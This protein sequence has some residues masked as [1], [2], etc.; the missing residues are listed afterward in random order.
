MR[1][2]LWLV[3]LCLSAA[4]RADGAILT[5]V[6]WLDNSTL[7]PPNTSIGYGLATVEVDTDAL[8][9]RLTA[10][11]NVLSGSVTGA[12][13]HCCTAVPGTGS[14]VA[15]SPVPYYPGFPTAFGG[16]YDQIFDATQSSTY[17][18]AFVTANGGT[19]S[20]AFTALLAGLDGGTAYFDLQTAQYPGGEIRGFLTGVPE[21]STALLLAAPL[22]VLA[23]LRLRYDRG[24]QKRNSYGGNN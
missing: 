17:N 8:T 15:A 19:V 14:A 18:P 13:I 7:P 16:T 10:S 21:P 23:L 24:T 11:F 9:L 5:Y 3:V 2:S 4:F 1:A 20:G 22:A 6:A 12:Q